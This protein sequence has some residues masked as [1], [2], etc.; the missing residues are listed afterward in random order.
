[1]LWLGGILIVLLLTPVW[2]AAFDRLDIW[3]QS[4]RPT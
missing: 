1:M 4:R 3:H 2:L